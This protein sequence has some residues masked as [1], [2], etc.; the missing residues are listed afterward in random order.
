MQRILILIYIFLMPTLTFAEIVFLSDREGKTDYYVMND[1]GGNVRKVTDTPFGI[2]HARWSRDGRQIAFAMDLH[3]EIPGNLQ[4]VAQQYEI[5]IMN[6]DGTRQHNLTEHPAQDGSPSWSPDGKSLVFD[7]SRAGGG[8]LELFMMDIASRQVRQLTHLG[9]AAS[10]DWS[11]DGK[12]IVFEY[13]KPGEGR[14]IYTINANGG[15]PHPVLRKQRKGR[16]GD[17]ATIS[18]FPSWSPDG[19][20]ILYSEMEIDAKRRI[21]NSVL[22]VNKDTRHL[23]TLDIPEK[24]K[25]DKA[26]WTDDGHAVLFA[27]VRNGLGKPSATDIF[28]I[29]RYD[30]N[31]GD[32]RNLTDHPSDN[33]GMDW[34]SRQRLSV[35]LTSIFTTQWGSIKNG[36]P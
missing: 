3:S 16:F 27:A 20:Y 32:I 31:S 6:R 29:Y 19:E 2:G 22:I 13:I 1:A 21:A 11:P 28:K 12:K 34:T 24:W 7:S 5:F 8:T 10:P 36:A 4:G 18:A 14:H 35:S 9:F 15:K 26:C 30:L 17:T 25:I 23:K 33:W